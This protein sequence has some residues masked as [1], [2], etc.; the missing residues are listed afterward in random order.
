MAT[1]IGRRLA[2]RGHEV[3]ALVPRIAELPTEEHEGSLTVDRVIERGVLPL[4]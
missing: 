1:E 4:T 3:T 2:E